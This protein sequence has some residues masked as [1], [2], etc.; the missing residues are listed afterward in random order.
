MPETAINKNGHLCPPKNDVGA[1]GQA[2]AMKAVS[3][4]PSM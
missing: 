3:Q 1:S 2:V 4:A